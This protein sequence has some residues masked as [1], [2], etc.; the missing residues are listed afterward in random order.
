MPGR[1]AS[2]NVQGA[3]KRSGL[4]RG[5][6]TAGLIGFGINNFKACV[7]QF[8]FVVEKAFTKEGCAIRGDE[9]AGAIFL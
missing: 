7:S 4:K 9:K 1:R 3:D 2:Q 6:A 8:F 5:A